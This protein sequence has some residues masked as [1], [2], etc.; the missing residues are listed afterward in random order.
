MF[1]VVYAGEADEDDVA[2][3]L[4]RTQQEWWEANYEDLDTL[5]MDRY[6]VDR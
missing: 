3:R 2:N 4:T 5:R 6:G 1:L